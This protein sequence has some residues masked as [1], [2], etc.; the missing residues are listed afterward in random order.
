MP[1]WC[2]KRM[3]S[4]FVLCES[5]SLAGGEATASSV[6]DAGRRSWIVRADVGFADQVDSMFAQVLQEAGQLD[7]VVNNAGVQTWAPLLELK[8]ERVTS[9]IS[10]D[11]FD[12]KEYLVMA[13]K[14]GI[15][16]RTALENY[17]NVRKGGI[18]GITLKEGDELVEVR[19]TDGEQE[20]VLATKKGQ[21]IRFKEKDA[22]EIGRTGQGVIG[23]RLKE[24]DDRVTV[25]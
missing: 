15:L 2:F 1:P 21:A 22:R 13:T 20:L 10:V 23:I 4:P 17:K 6:R 9:W 19:K 12:T 5:R 7:L 24:K 3:A 11:K 8:E 14:N 25:P 16:K 18:I